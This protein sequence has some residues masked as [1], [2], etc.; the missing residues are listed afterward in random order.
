MKR[1]SPAVY[2]L[3]LILILAWPLAAQDSAALAKGKQLFLGM[4]SRC[5]GITGGGGEGPNLNRPVLE[6]APD[7][8]TLLA[9]IRDGIPNTGMPRVRRMT[10]SELNSLVIFVRSLG[11]VEAADVSGNPANGRAVYAKLGC[12]GCHT[13]AGEGGDFGPELTNIGAFRAPDY[14][15]QAIVDPAAALPKGIRAVPGR[16]FN[17]YLPV[18]VVM[19]D[20]QEVRGI[21]LNEDSFTI[22]V[23]D[24][25]G[26]LHS[27]RKTDLQAL[28]K[29][30]GQSLMPNYS[31]KVSGSD[32]DDLVAY[33]WTLRG[34]K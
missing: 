33:L 5:H 28:D 31:A 9:V 10:D 8:K 7:D 6:R 27:F 19:R 14:L 21:R 1:F 11:K 32:L 12:S 25:S 13:V 2:N 18:R 23:R 15:R 29:E 26:Q 24:M 16:G 30:I 20:G 34:A 4:C 3:V 22:Q 17:E